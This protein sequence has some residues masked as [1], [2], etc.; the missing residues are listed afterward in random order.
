MTYWRSEFAGDDNPLPIAGM[1]AYQLPTEILPGRM[2]Y[3]D[4]LGQ[5]DW[6]PGPKVALSSR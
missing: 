4:I 2:N 1:V 3:Q 5:F 6:H